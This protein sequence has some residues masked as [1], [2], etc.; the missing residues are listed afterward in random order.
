MDLPI[1]TLT[2]HM[3]L[4]NHLQI[5]YPVYVLVLKATI[6]LLLHGIIRF[7]VW[8]GN[9]MELTVFSGGCDEQVKIWPLMSGG[10]P[11]IVAIHDAEL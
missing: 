4:F 1:K 7:C 6:L 10:Q 3:R 5:L 11:V 8:L 2:N 9:M